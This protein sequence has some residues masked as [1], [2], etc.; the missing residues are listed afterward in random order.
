MH[1]LRIDQWSMKAIGSRDHLDLGGRFH[2]DLA[3]FD[4]FSKSHLPFLSERL[5]AAYICWIKF[6]LYVD[7]LL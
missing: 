1:V 6:A 4:L 7:Q 3:R 5:N 2:D